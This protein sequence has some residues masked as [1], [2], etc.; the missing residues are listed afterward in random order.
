MKSTRRLGGH[1]SIA[2][3][4]SLSLDRAQ[5]IGA[6]CLQ[7]FAASPRSW[8]RA[9]FSTDQAKE[10]NQQ[11]KASD[12]R[13]VFI[14]TLYLVNLA[15]DNPRIYNKSIS[16]LKSDMQSGDLIKSAGVIIHLGSHQGRG[17]GAVS[18]QVV[19]SI[20]QILIAM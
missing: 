20:K 11:I 9:P 5:K 18:G 15:S 4:L 10:F 3:G 14:H 16:A 6:N 2:G 19:K 7:I 13:P 17:F 12:L 1:V 8:D